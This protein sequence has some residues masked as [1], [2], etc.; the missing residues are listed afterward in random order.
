M[1][2]IISRKN[3]IHRGSIYHSVTHCSVSK[4]GSPH[5]ACGGGLSSP[6]SLPQ[7]VESAHEAMVCTRKTVRYT[8]LGRPA[9]A[10]RVVLVLVFVLWGRGIWRS[11][12]APLPLRNGLAASFQEVVRGQREVLLPVRLLAWSCRGVPVISGKGPEPLLCRR[13]LLRAWTLA[14]T[15]EPQGSLWERHDYL[16]QASSRTFPFRRLFDDA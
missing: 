4:C 10:E 14:A 6:F 7:E 13:R 5:P 16:P 12:H 3:E 1:S 8:C 9:E 2:L 15:T 11:G